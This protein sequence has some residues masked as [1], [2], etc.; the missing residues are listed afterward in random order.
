MRS[1]CGS[2]FSPLPCADNTK[3]VEPDNQ[4]FRT[5]LAN[6]CGAEY[7][8]GAVC[9]DE[10]QLDSL[11]NQ[12]KQAESI[13]ASC[14]ACWKNFL[15][16]WCSFTCSPNQSTFVNITSTD[17][18]QGVTS[19][20]Y[21]VGDHFG[22]QFFDSCKDIQFGSSNS[23]AMDFIGG[24][25]KDWYEMVTYMGMKRPLV[26]SPFQIDFPRLSLE[27]SEGLSRYDQDGKLCND[28]DP[29]YRCACV[30]CQSVCPIL[31]PTDKEK[32]ECRIG[33]LRCWTFAMLMTYVIVLI[34]AATLLLA[35]NKV[36]GRWLQKFFGVHLDQLEARGLYERLALAED[37]DEEEEQENLLDPDYT[38]RRYWLNSRLQ[39]WFYYQGLFCARYPWLVILVS[40]TF[41]SL[42]SLGWSRLEI[43]RSPV[44]LWVSPTSTAL[45]QKNYFDTHFTPFYRTTQ[46]FFVSETDSP[47]AS[48]ERIQNLFRLEQEIEAVRSSKYQTKLQDVCF[49]PTGDACILQSITGYWQGDID[50]FDPDSW[51]E[52]LAGC[53][54]QPSTCLP[55][56]L[57]PLKPEMILGG[58]KDEDYMT[59]RAF[60]VTYVLRNSMNATETAKAEDWE[61]TL[62]ETVLSG[63]EERAEWK[64]VKI[65]Y[66]TEGSLETELNKSS[67]TDVKTVIISYLVMFIYASFALGRISSF[68]PR[69]FFVDSKFGLGVCGILIVI[70]SVSTAVGLF[71]LTGRKI[72]LIIAEVIPFLVLAVG[73]DNIFILC[74]EYQRRAELDQDESIEERT[75]KTLGKMG[76]S[77]LLSSASETIAFGLGTMVT[78]P[79]VSS[80]A[81]MA[82]V[83]VFIDFVLQVTCFVSCLALDARRMKDQR[84][85]CVPCVRIKAPETIE[86]E[87]WLESVIRQYYV[88]TILH[89][90]IRY[91]VCLAFLGL[92]MFGLSLLPQVPLG[93]DQRIALPSDSYLVQYFND[94]DHYFNVGPP[95]YFVVKGANLTSRED[96][97]KICGRFPA[98][99]ERSLANTLELERKR[100]NVSYI[101]EP[102]SVWLDDFMLWLNPNVECCRFKK[103]RNTSPRRRKMSALDMAYD[104]SKRELCGP[105]DD[106]ESCVDCVEGYD[107]SMEAIPEGKAFLDLYNIWIERVPDESCP[108]AGKAAYG[109]AVVANPEQT[110]IESSH[111]RTFHTPLRSQE[112]FISAYASARR[113]ARDLSQELGLDIFPYSV[114]Y[115]FFE[116]Y[117]Y[118]VSMA[119]QILGFAILSIF[120]VSSSLLGSLRCGLL[121]MSVVI[122]IL[123]D[124]VGV[125][126]LWGVSLNAVSLVN[127]VICI[128]ISVEF[129]CHIARGFMVA[130]GSL[131]DRA[132]KSMVDIGSSVFCG[133]TLTK[134]AGIVVLAF[135]RS[136]IFEVY[137]FRM[138]LSIVV[139]GALHGLVLLP[140]LL[141][142]FG[143]EG[144]ALTAEFDEDGSSINY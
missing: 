122:M 43:E 33:L 102:T 137:Y 42:C 124:V 47:I 132:G 67:N 78:M 52:D 2:P 51:Q 88:P 105:W 15:Q 11:I 38:P 115:I 91:V 9:C 96:Q 100:S 24:S 45:E 140:I 92:F 5:L 39:N 61:K 90:K 141:S 89:H 101:G 17:D 46:I 133:I 86:K 79:A 74:H 118:I 104:A 123:V 62:L 66:S 53:T 16:F 75:A 84:V 129:C 23:F 19:A 130:S 60:V 21:W 71:S 48:A 34:L 31:P 13:I 112:Q 3:A 95:V 113:I 144:M 55:E 72:T 103:P 4:S 59:A 28:T 6:T 25:A 64:G 142:M 111:F 138:Y 93:L 117:T 94:L 1:Q 68:N 10:S 77:I 125:M 85:D 37:D 107:S 14:P 73:V 22:T 65:S 36:I 127:L 128:G 126:T 8:T 44:N 97:Q 50:N 83:A 26:G 29:A 116:Q 54:T 58:Y 98:C 70:F 32:P 131:E 18:H 106:P 143:G 109:D 81:I 110:T 87:G 30:D 114:F 76:P 20:D 7:S 35:K 40:L 82:S 134:F 56:S 139:L 69:R 120:I 57:Q 63:L 136:K 41:V 27:P 80:F 135:T 99:E 108:L 121:V 119:F 49:H 12:A